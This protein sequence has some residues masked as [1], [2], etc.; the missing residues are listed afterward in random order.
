MADSEGEAVVVEC[1]QVMVDDK[2]AVKSQ[3]ARLQ[4]MLADDDL[5]R[6]CINELFAKLEAIRTNRPSPL[7][8][9]TSSNRCAS[10]AHIRGCAPSVVSMVSMQ[11]FF[12]WDTACRWQKSCVL[13][14]PHIT[15]N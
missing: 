1:D 9:S 15:P 12:A 4:V 8:Q 14:S 7:H 6:G 10:H 5:S 3:H 13:E 11:F 2:E